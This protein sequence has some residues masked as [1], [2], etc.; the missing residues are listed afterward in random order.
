[1]KV[2][3][4][5]NAAIADTLITLTNM[6]HELWL[7]STG[8]TFCLAGPAGNA[9]RALLGP[10]ARCD[11]TVEADSAFEAMTKYY[12]YMGWGNYKTDFPEIEMQPYAQR[13]DI[14]R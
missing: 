11:W 8:Q 2:A 6:L 9:H 7:E 13:N 12:E 4:G 5:H 3:E 10:D 1:M 14:V